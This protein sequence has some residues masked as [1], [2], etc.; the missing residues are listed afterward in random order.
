[1]PML[2][3]WTQ[4]KRSKV[5][6]HFRLPTCHRKVMGERLH[7]RLHQLRARVVK[8]SPL[9]NIKVVDSEPAKEENPEENKD[10]QGVLLVGDTGF[11]PATSTMSTLDFQLL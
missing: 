7:Q 6:R 1:M 4:P 3:C 8:T 10:F 11:E 5:Y 2:G 9:L